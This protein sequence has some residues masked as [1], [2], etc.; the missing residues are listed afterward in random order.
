MY[1]SVIDSDDY[2]TYI[3]GFLRDGNYFEE[4]ILGSEYTQRMKQKRSLYIV[5]MREVNGTFRKRLN[6]RVL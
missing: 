1:F 3:A 6:S 5:P 2:M 4:D